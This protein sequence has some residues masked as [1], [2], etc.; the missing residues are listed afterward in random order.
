ME[1]YNKLSPEET[2]R[3]A[4]LA[5]ECGEV[6]QVIGKILRHGYESYNPFD[7][8]KNSNRLLLHKE[9]TNV[10]QAMTRMKANKDLPGLQITPI[11]YHNLKYWHHQPEVNF[12]IKE[13]E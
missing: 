10:L 9:L 8:E 1:N 11:C 2:E 4:Y 6:I 12:D 7:E 5:E 13:N 3:L